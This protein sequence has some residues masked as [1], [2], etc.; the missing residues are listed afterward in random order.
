M[1]SWGEEAGVVEDYRYLGVHLKNRLDWT[2]NTNAVYKK[3][4]SRLYFLR[5]LRSFNV[6][7]K[8]LEIFYQS[9]MASAI[10]FAVVCWGS[11][12]SARDASRTGLRDSRAHSSTD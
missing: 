4:M 5:K 10:Y 11:S 12:I 1:T 6:C 8:M 2:T 7:S 9:V 3:K